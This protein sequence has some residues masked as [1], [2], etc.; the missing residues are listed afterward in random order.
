MYRRLF[1][2]KF[3]KDFWPKTFPA[4]Q[5]SGA[6]YKLLEVYSVSQNAIDSYTFPREMKVERSLFKVCKEVSYN[7]LYAGS[8]IKYFGTV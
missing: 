3:V 8:T 7:E 4:T 5:S 1:T 2:E 6:G